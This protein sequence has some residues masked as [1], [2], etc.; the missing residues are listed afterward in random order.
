M[1]DGVMQTTAPKPVAEAQT[2]PAAADGADAAADEDAG[3][4]EDDF[5]GG[6]EMDDDELVALQAEQ[7]VRVPQD[8]KPYTTACRSEMCMWAARQSKVNKNIGSSWDSE[9]ACLT[10]AAGDSCAR[11]HVR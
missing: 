1:R 9:Q 2:T 11:G 8:P 3:R 7:W 10:F 4:Y 6:G 5:G